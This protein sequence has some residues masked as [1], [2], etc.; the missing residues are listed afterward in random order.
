[1]SFPGVGPSQRQKIDVWQA[2]AAD[3]GSWR[4]GDTLCAFQPLAVFSVHAED[5]T[6]DRIRTRVPCPLVLGR[7]V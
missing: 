3:R 4:F 5:R 1:M 2:A 7:S 6:E